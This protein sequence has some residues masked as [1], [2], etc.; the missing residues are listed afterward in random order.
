M[1]SESRYAVCEEEETCAMCK[2]DVQSEFVLS[3]TTSPRVD[4]SLLRVFH[5][6]FVP[7]VST[8][9]V[10]PRGANSA[11]IDSY[12]SPLPHVRCD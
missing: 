8:N 2:H 4:I 5:S 3:Q 10:A 1:E 9:H 7:F 6:Y 12:Y 11:S